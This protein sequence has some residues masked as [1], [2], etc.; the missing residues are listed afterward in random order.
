MK[1]LISFSIFAFCLLLVYV[2][3]SKDDTT[4]TT[5]IKDLLFKKWIISSLNPAPII[6]IEFVQGDTF[7]VK[8]NDGTYFANKYSISADNKTIT[9]NRFGTMD[10]N[11]IN[12]SAFDFTL[13]I[14]STPYVI[15]TT[16]NA[17]VSSSSRT[18]FICQNWNLRKTILYTNTLGRYDTVNYPLATTTVGTK[19]TNLVITTNSTYF[20]TNSNRNAS[21]QFDTTY[22]G[23]NWQWKDAQEK[24]ICIGDPSSFCN[25]NNELQAIELTNNKLTFQQISLNRLDTLTSFFVR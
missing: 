22:A 23:R 1:R 18:I 2:S 7:F 25:G 9:L 15:T 13:R 10:V 17:F 11:A 8:K 6:W 3:C 4:V 24:Y 14:S 12:S 5:P 21:G 20:L 19:A 16:A